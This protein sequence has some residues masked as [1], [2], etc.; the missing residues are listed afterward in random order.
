MRLVSKFEWKIILALA[1]TAAAPLLFT[2]FM[3]DRLVEESMSV[4]L[5]DQ[6]LGNLRTGVD[7]Y[8]EVIEARL[9]IVRLQGQA[10]ARDPNLLKPG[11]AVRGE[12]IR[13]SLEGLLASNPAIRQARLLA[14]DQELFAADSQELFKEDEYKFKTEQWELGSDRRLEVTFAISKAFLAASDRLRELVVTLESVQANFQPWKMGYYRL[15]L[16]IYTWILVA[17]VVLGVL[18]SR[19]VTKR[20]A[21]L[22]SATKRAALGDLTVRVPIKGRDEI[23]SLTESFNQ[24]MDDIQRGRDR[25][26]YLE[27]VSSW[28]DIARRLAHE[29]KNPLTPIQLA[30]QE[31]H[32]SYRGGD[33][34]FGAKLNDSLEIVEEEVGTLRRMVETFSEFAKMP[35]VQAVS[36][37]ISGFV[38]EFLKH[39]PHI[40][41]RVVFEPPQEPVV[42]RLDKALMGRVLMNLVTNGLEASP[43]EGKVT[44]AIFKGPSWGT[45]R[46]SDR[47]SGLAPEARARIFQ[48]YFTTKTHGTGLGL[49]I[50][51][52]IVLQHGGEIAVEDG[53][54]GGTVFEVRL[55]L[56]GARSMAVS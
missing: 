19:S 32:R 48:P 13:Q 40:S 25:I 43:P 29:I 35:D 18:L 53:K 7:L 8:K 30:I 3:V 27:K 17:A 36:M 52:K 46:V 5:N 49:A 50:V 10:L 38:Q 9:K 12:E 56:E 33:A 6:V 23:G 45:L 51:K 15:F 1:V 4:G 26:V 37:E 2:M 47:G 20:V 34:Q 14:A 54:D 44:V 41:G 22:F 24:M 16:F 21:T 28:Q 31:L 39:N 55:Q 42:V 11:T